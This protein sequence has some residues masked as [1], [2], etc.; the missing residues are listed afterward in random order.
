M[1][2][3]G[4]CALLKFVKPER[5]SLALRIELQSGVELVTTLGTGGDV[6]N[7]AW[8]ADSTVIGCYDVRAS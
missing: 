8:R 6:R 7:A 5:E 4:D 1:R 3:R 2:W